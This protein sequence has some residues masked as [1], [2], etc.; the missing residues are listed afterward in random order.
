MPI[1]VYL[2]LLTYVY[3]SLFEFIYVYSSL[4]KSIGV[5]LLLFESINF[6]FCLFWSKNINFVIY[7]KARQACNKNQMKWATRSLVNRGSQMHNVQQKS[8]NYIVL[9][10]IVGS[11]AEKKEASTGNRGF[12][13]LVKPD[14]RLIQVKAMSK[15]LMRNSPEE[16]SLKYS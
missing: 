9:S 5:Y 2:S 10:K 6:I 1:Q 7:W 13:S 3:S 11:W 12:Y 15:L 8:Q 14:K 16:D 4:Q